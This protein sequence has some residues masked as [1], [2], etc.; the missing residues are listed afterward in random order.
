M[1]GTSTVD[2][3]LTGNAC[4][5]CRDI[6]GAGATTECVEGLNRQQ[7]V[8]NP[9]MK[10]YVISKLNSSAEYISGCFQKIDSMRNKV[11]VSR[12]DALPSQSLCQRL[13]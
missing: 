8:K 5:T 13:K 7:G 6:K 10:G 4:R 3:T 1:V 12:V 11:N 9:I 2:Q